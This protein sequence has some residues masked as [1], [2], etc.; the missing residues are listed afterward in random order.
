[1]PTD[2][3]LLLSKA[4]GLTYR[5]IA[6]KYGLNE[7]SVR[8][9]VSRSST[10]ENFIRL[11][12]DMTQVGRL[13]QER[14]EQS[15]IIERAIAKLDTIRN[16]N[17]LTILNLADIHFPYQRQDALRL[18]YDIA[19]QFKPNLVIEHDVFDFNNYGRWDNVE[20]DSAT[21]WSQDIS[22]AIEVARI[23]HKLLEAPVLMLPSNHDK[24]LFDYLRR[25]TD[26]FSEQK[27][28]MWMKALENQGVLQVSNDPKQEMVVAIKDWRF[29][30]GVTA[31]TNNITMGKTT[32]E[33]CATSGHVYNTM[34][35]HVHRSFEVSH[36]GVRHINTGC[37]CRFDMP[38]LSH[39]PNWQLGVT[40]LI[41]EGKEWEC[42]NVVFHEKGNKLTAKVRGIYFETELE[43]QKG[44]TI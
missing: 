1:M 15:R 5:E 29:V 11:V 22:N 6:G 4:T 9:R 41:L 3:D 24:R 7:D 31:S 39:R 13:S 42:D 34:S 43:K 8:G 35:G 38:Y 37:L 30:H 32:I 12:G 14:V 2:Y 19:T 33:H 44:Y 16:K 27:I 25:S 20:S 40:L 21:L 28:L 17:K 26:G 10:R 36:M 18:A 23:H